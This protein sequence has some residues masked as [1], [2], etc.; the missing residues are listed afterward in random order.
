ML[1]FFK[2]HTVGTTFRVPA[3]LRE[4]TRRSVAVTRCTESVTWSHGKKDSALLGHSQESFP[5]QLSVT[6]GVQLRG[7]AA[8]GEE[9]GISSAWN[10]LVKH[11]PSAYLEL[12]LEACSEVRLGRGQAARSPQDNTSP[13]MLAPLPNS[14]GPQAGQE[15]KSFLTF[16]PKNDHYIRFTP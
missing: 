15:F 14:E 5:K 11:D 8:G 9:E 2:E 13:A 3:T 6:W 1:R 7:R 10:E 16:T 12:W 4:E